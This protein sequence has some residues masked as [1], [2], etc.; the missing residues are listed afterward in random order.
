MD[1]ELLRV[2][3]EELMELKLQTR[4]LREH[5]K[6]AE[7]RLDLE[8]EEANRHTGGAEQAFCDA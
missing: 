7:Q 5:T 4:E 6:L 1:S 8:R 3:N 2:L